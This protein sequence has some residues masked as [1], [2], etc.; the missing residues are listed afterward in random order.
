MEEKPYKRGRISVFEATE[1]ECLISCGRSF[2]KVGASNENLR[3]NC[4]SDE[5]TD[6]TNL[7]T[8]RNKL[9]GCPCLVLYLC[10]LREL[11]KYLG[12]PVCKNLYTSVAVMENNGKEVVLE[13]A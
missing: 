8:S 6:G 9:L 7:R 11:S 2:H 1:G 3:P 13:V 12:L 4:F 10:S 5:K